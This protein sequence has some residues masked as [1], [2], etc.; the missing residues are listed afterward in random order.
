MQRA[1]PAAH[2]GNSSLQLLDLRVSLLHI[3]LLMKFILYLGSL[4]RVLRTI[5]MK[6]SML[7]RNQREFCVASNP[8]EISVCRRKYKSLIDE[9]ELSS[10]STNQYFS[11]VRPSVVLIGHLLGSDRPSVSTDRPFVSTDRSNTPYASAASTS[12]CANASESSFVYLG[13]KIPID[14]S[15]R[16]NADL[17]IDLNTPDLEDASDTLP[18][19]GIFNGAYDD[20]KVIHKDHPKGQILGDPTL[21]VQT[22]G[23]I[24]KAFS[25]QQA[26]PYKMKVGF[27]AARGIASV[28]NYSSYIDVTVAGKPVTISE[29]S[30]RS[31]L[32]FNDADGIDSLKLTQA[33][34][35]IFSNNGGSGGNHG[36]QS[37]NDAS[38]SGN[39]DGLTLQ[40][41]YDL[42][43]SGQEH[44][45]TQAKE[46]K[47]LKP[48]VKKLKKGVKPLITHHKAWMKTKMEDPAF[49]D[50]DDLWLW[51]ILSNYMETEDD[52]D[53]GGMKVRHGGMKVFDKEIV[54]EVVITNT[55][56]STP[57]PT[58]P[59]PT[60]FGDDETIT[61]VLIIMSQNKEKLKEKGK[62]VE[63][64]NLANDDE[65]ARK[66]KEEWEAEE[67]K[68]R[69]VEEE[70]TKA[71]LSN[72]YDFIQVR[73]NAD[74]ILAEEL[75]KEEREKFTIEQRAKFL[76]DTIAAQRKFLAQQRSEAIKN[77]PPTRNQLRNQ[78]MTYLKYVGGKKHSELKTK[79]FEEI[80]VLYKKLKRQDQNFVAIGSAENERQI[81]E[82]N[83]ESKD[84][85]K[86]R[87]K[88][89]SC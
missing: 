44:V 13:G 51:M 65:V 71:A 36:G 40:S 28:Q 59:T 76:H 38:L 85:E 57:T 68:K 56:Y 78:M 43:V 18:N 70:A 21:A 61:Q 12:T 55:Q 8:S 47:A 19:D 10:Y 53:R 17:P 32:L 72:E 86:K 54:W 22:R 42:Y 24:Q 34:L 15:T 7:V 81:K 84:P 60:V 11:I 2:L 26:L 25:A 23:K 82:M 30:I 27:E 20:D 37:S 80:Q 5:A 35:I 87:L 16:P 79:S 75:Q 49:D 48:Q 74:K 83:E 9:L 88:K 50:L 58:T 73:L 14:A 63:I 66:V 67:E 45:T 29:A 41:I 39:E 1:L 46:I 31:G 3:Y 64:R 6:N 89:R 52:Q 33:N 4:E 77:K 69:L 62:G